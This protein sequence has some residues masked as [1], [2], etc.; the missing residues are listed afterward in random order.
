[1]AHAFHYIS[2]HDPKVQQACRDLLEIIHKVQN[3]VR[4]NFT[5][6][7]HLVGSY[8]RNMITYDAKSNVGFDFDINLI[9]NPGAE[10]YS[11]KDINDILRNALNKVVTGY[12]YSPPEDST[13]VL[14]IKLIDQHRSIIKHSCD[15]AILRKR[16]WGNISY[17]E[18]IHFDKNFRTY[19]WNR[20]AEAE[21]MSEEIQWLKEHNLWEQLRKNYITKKNS[22]RDPHTHSRQ[23][24]SSAVKELYHCNNRSRNIPL[25]DFLFL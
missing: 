13:R 9:L 15:V 8:S 11:P 3:E 2:K 14:T 25:D 10:D 1:M 23:I 18:Y 4:D 7:Y 20:L 16:Q 12:R 22:N 24:F 5:F 17:L 19:L 21:D 6:Q